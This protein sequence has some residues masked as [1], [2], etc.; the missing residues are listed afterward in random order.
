MNYASINDSKTDTTRPK[1]KKVFTHALQVTSLI[2]SVLCS[3]FLILMYYQTVSLSN[4]FQ[5]ITTL[6]QSVNNT[7]ISLL[8]NDLLKLETCALQNLQMCQ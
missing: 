2:S 5:L 3:V 7:K 4:S 8:T 1:K 6:I